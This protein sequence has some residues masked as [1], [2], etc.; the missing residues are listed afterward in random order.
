MNIV[1][2]QETIDLEE[3]L[4]DFL[5]Q[6]YRS[7]MNYLASDLLQQGLSSSE[8]KS[9]IQRAMTIAD[10]SGIDTQQHFMPVFTHHQ[11]GIIRDCKLTKMGYG[12]VILNANPEN[13]IVGKWQTKILN[14]Y[15]GS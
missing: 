2:Y 6:V 10:S 3:P 4:N 7:Q 9:A 14:S 5:N 12:M 13:P 11:S 1:I 15:F 8:I